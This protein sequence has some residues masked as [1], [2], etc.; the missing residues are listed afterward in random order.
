KKGIPSDIAEQS[1]QKVFEDKNIKEVLLH[2]VLKGKRRF[3]REEDPYKRK[4]KVVDHLARKGYRPSN[5]Y[6]HID[7]LMKA[8][9]Q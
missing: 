7:E 4:K 3:L 1:I 5:I 2:L 6:N 8:I 9:E